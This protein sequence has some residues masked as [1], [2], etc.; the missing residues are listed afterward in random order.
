MSKLNVGVLGLSHDHVWG[1][2]SALA[3]GELGRVAAVAEP[4]AELRAKVRD[5]HGGVD[6]HETFDA[7]L[8]RRDLHAVLIFSDN[9]TSAELGVR[10]GCEFD[11]NSGA[12]VKVH[13]LKLK[14]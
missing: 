8:E 11:K 3:T 6:V 1:N 5:L 10:A 14:D 7:L 12:P 2:L 13:T 4:D 9:R